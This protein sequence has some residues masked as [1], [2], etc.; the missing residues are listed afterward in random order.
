MGGQEPASSYTNQLV[1]T[2]DGRPL[3]PEQKGSLV[4]GWVDSSVNMPASFQL[5]FRDPHQR[6]LGELKVKLGSKVVLRA[7][8]VGKDGGRPLFTGE[9]T[10]LEADFDGTGKYSVV[11][12]HDPGH[13]LLRNRRVEGYENMTAS[14]IARKLA[15]R[16]KLKVG[17]IDPTRTVYDRITQPN[18]T[19]WDFLTRLARENGV[20]VYFSDQGM[21]QF[22]EP[23]P[24]S[25]APGKGT[26]AGSSPYVL[27]FGVNLLRCRTGV[28]ASDQVD[29]VRVRGWDVRL[30]KGV[31]GTATA[32]TNPE[33]AIGLTGK[34][35]TGPFGKAELVET[36]VPYDTYAQVQEAANSLAADVSAA[37]A[38]LE[39][40]VRG[41][42]K[43]RPGLPVALNGIGRPFEGKYT[44]T[45]ARHVFM[46]GERYE[47]WLTVSGRQHRSLFGLASGSA[48]PAAPKV[49]GVASAIVTDIQDPRNE[50]RV[51]LRFPWLDG[52]YVSDWAR[53]VQF[54]G[55]RGG[56]LLM[57]DVNDEVLVAFDRGALD[58]P[59]VIGGLYN[60]HDRLP[61]YQPMPVVGPSGRVNWRSVASRTGN[62]IEL[63][64]APAR[65][66]VKISSGDDRMTVE[67]RETGTRLTV[68]SDGTVDISGTRAVTIDG[69][70]VTIKAATR[71]DLRSASIGLNAANIALNG[72]SIAL[73]G[74]NI[75]LTGMVEATG[76]MNVTPMLTMNNK[77]VMIVPV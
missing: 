73:T 51:K 40:E 13:R 62:R 58:H 46:N 15:S 56:G 23:K 75:R 16:N 36:G 21:F 22:V 14:D 77:L 19:D 11:R 18:V 37:F 1:V 52:T 72:A 59:Y 66:G 30:K 6:V 45:S 38:E 20:D 17:R 70:V 44:V 7:M 50:G 29:R 76:K 74:A 24:A 5:S 49:P 69:S 43:L 12:G 48:G 34:A 27:E 28:T 42:P 61:R 35:A 25:G 57:P 60:G 55:V 41:D 68:R 8:A 31:V 9:V 47:T 54:G 26:K 67:M 64:D 71:L 63:L 2:I 53:V 65:Q 3:T 32:T 4:E 39:A 10:A 33:L